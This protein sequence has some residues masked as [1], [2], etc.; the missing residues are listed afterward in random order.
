MRCLIRTVLLGAFVVATGCSDND[1]NAPLDVEVNPRRL[2]RY[3]YDNTVR[4]LL[5]T[6]QR[7]SR[8]FPEQPRGLGFDNV[9]SL[10]TSSADD[11]LRFE[12]AASLL[13]EEA[14]QS[15][16]ASCD[17]LQ[18]RECA[19]NIIESL[20]PR[21]WRR[22]L[23]E[24]ERDRLLDLYDALIDTQAT[25]DEARAGVLEA[26]LLS[27]AFLYRIEGDPQYEM[28]SRLSYFLWSSMPDEAL[29]DA[30]ARGQLHDPEE[31]EA[32][33]A[34]MLDDDKSWALVQSFA[35]QWLHF[36]ALDDVFKDH[37]R[38]PNFDESLRASMR[39]ELDQFFASFL[40]EDRDLRTLLTAQ[41]TMV[42]ARLHAHYGVASAPFEGTKPLDL[43][44][45]PRRG[46]MTMPG[47]MAVL[48]RPFRTAP[49]KRGAWVLSQLMCAPPPPPPAGVEGIAEKI[50]GDTTAERL[51]QHR[52]DPSC[53]ACHDAIDPIGLAFE[54]YDAIGR[55]RGEAD[56][57]PID[58]SGTLANGFEF[59]DALELSSHI[60]Q[61]EQFVEC[62]AQQLMT[63]AL[64]RALEED[65]EIEL[66]EI[67]QT[68]ATHEYR[69]RTLFVLIAQS[70]AFAGVR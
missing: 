68:W 24:G 58:A 38:F 36:R 20:A 10:Q 11:V 39:T 45:L 26:L 17:A 63:Y 25:D 13:A 22:P 19:A 48:A 41:T 60:A 21:A 51:A 55:W 42:D 29:F 12:H 4:D 70:D 61:S 40:R 35:G 65:D 49:V 32:Q 6:D 47:M 34:R 46:L 31:I 3:E 62:A 37:S 16:V 30:A 33:V 50:E 27:P 9:Q 52:I 1:R 44:R 2:T 8:D 28:A 67:V 23:R 15:S 54:H 56:D 43:S 7:P 5:G 18:G 53:A 66:E 64:G 57:V 14:T 69:T 59:E